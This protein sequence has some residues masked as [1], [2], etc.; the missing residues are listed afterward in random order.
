MSVPKA[1]ARAS[2]DPAFKAPLSDQHA[3]LADHGID[4]P[5]GSAVKAV[6]DAGAVRHIVLPSSPANPDGMEV[7]ELERIT[8][9][10]PTS[11]TCYKG[12]C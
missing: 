7:E 12:S 3:A 6:E 9:A 8:P 4:V 5:A 2:T 11:E 1:V 10:Y